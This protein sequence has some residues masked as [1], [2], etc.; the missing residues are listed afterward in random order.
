MILDNGA[1][2]LDQHGQ[3]VF[4]EVIPSDVVEGIAKILEN[5][6]G[7]VAQQVFYHGTKEWQEPGPGTTKIRCWTKDAA[8]SQAIYNMV[9]SKYGDAV[10]GTVARTAVMSSL[11]W[12]ENPEEYISF[13]DIMS[14][15]A[16]K[17]KTIWR[18]SERYPNEQITTVGDGTNDLEMIQE[19]DGYA[20]RN[21]APE[22]LE[23]VKPG[24]II[25]SVEELLGKL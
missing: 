16:G 11:D 3:E 21:S 7:D 13:V 18:L 25:E 10:Y 22:V 1:I 14:A 9:D 2:C 24:H 5:E 12:I 20:M 8:V 17:N 4:R 15:G 6:F 23:I 19:F